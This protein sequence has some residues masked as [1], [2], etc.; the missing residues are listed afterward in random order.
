MFIWVFYNQKIL[1]MKHIFNTHLLYRYL[2]IIGV[3]C[4]QDFSQTLYGQSDCD[5]D[6][7]QYYSFCNQEITL[8]YQNGYNIT[9]Q[10]TSA[11]E[12]NC[13]IILANSTGGTTIYYTYPQVFR[14]I[15]HKEI[16][17][18]QGVQ[19]LGIQGGF[20]DCSQ[21]V[22]TFDGNDVH[23]I[24]IRGNYCEGEERPIIGM[25]A[26]NYNSYSPSTG[27]LVGADTS[28]DPYLNSSGQPNYIFS[29]GDADP[30]FDN[31]GNPNFITNSSQQKVQKDCGYNDFLCNRKIIVWCPYAWE[32]R[33]IISLHGVER[34]WIEDIGIHNASG[35]DGIHVTDDRDF[36]V[37]RD[38]DLNN[39][40]FY[41]NARNGMKVT[42]AYCMDLKGL[43]L[44]YNGELAPTNIVTA[45]AGFNLD[46]NT[47]EG[48]IDD[49]MG[50]NPDYVMH[51]IF[52]ETSSFDDNKNRSLSIDIPKE[53]TLCDQSAKVELNDVCFLNNDH[54][55]FFE[56]STL[57]QSGTFYFDD[58]Y[59]D[60]FS[61][62]VYVSPDWISNS[63]LS[64][65]RDL[66]VTKNG[67]G[68]INAFDIQ[69]ATFCSS[70]LVSDI[71]KSSN[72][73][74]NLCV[75][76]LCTTPGNNNCPIIYDPE[77]DGGG[78]GDCYF[79]VDSECKEEVEYNC[80]C[81]YLF[82]VD[83]S[84][85]VDDEEW[86]E[87][88]C[89][90]TNMMNELDSICEE[91]CDTRFALIQWATGQHLGSNFDCLPFEFEQATGIGG[92][93][94]PQGALQ[95]LLN[96]LQSGEEFQPNEECFKIMIFTDYGCGSRWSDTAPIADLI[97]LLYPN[98]EFIVVDYT[99]NGVL[100]DCE[101]VHDVV[102]NADGEYDPEDIIQSEFN[103]ETGIGIED[104]ADTTL[105]CT[106]VVE[107]DPNC[108][109]PTI[110]WE[111]YDGG[112]IT[113]VSQ[114]QTTITTN[115]E[116]Y[117]IVTVECESGC[118][119]IFAEYVQ[120][121]N[122][123]DSSSKVAGGQTAIV[124]KDRTRY[125]QGVAY[126][127]HEFEELMIREKQTISVDI[128]TVPNPITDIVQV[129]L[130]DKH[131]FDQ[132]KIFNSHGEIVYHAYLQT[133]NL[134]QIDLSQLIDGLYMVR[135][136]NSDKLE[137]VSHSIL[138]FSNQ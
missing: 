69:S 35:G 113:D 78:G 15:S 81:D 95:F 63:I 19:L 71:C 56:N 9:N 133:D 62:A 107:I 45:E 80:D 36:N 61:S 37:A 31:N 85:S 79:Y 70:I 68:S 105:V 32:A 46:Q 13:R 21:S 76:T 88:N 90:I 59:I 120:F 60:E 43:N 86:E 126:T 74:D 87:M 50:I 44:H 117:Y 58:I 93:T 127:P 30:Y 73:S 128:R 99:T 39:V 26:A 42:N 4:C 75:P 102:D 11:I 47:S 27:Y 48:S 72:I 49:Y 89:S 25:T 116:G 108:D 114:D 1:K 2:I 20:S 77:C 83:E 131:E 121:S 16:I 115:G 6:Q 97:K 135:L 118:N 65:W 52:L 109:N 82:M 64:K 138:K 38:I 23:D 14:N 98:A 34:V 103:C 91:P 125:Y 40:Y 57:Q 111:A 66:L 101:G 12:N 51:N 67:S 122:N 136:T 119:S 110:T 124:K 54:T 29:D 100:E 17:L 55:V 10:L 7:N 137:S 84:G 123:F 129:Y 24:L 112:E 18:E 134:L 22:L 41:E 28:G 96:L 132:I 5:C 92:G 106:A 8:A 53:L 94:N 104:I 33:H 130:P 3:L